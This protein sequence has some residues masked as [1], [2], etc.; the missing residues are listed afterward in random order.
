MFLEKQEYVSEL[1]EI[2][3]N[4]HDYRACSLEGLPKAGLHT[5]EVHGSSPCVSTNKKSEP[6]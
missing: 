1:K 6:I 5:Q 2:Y 4:K 3:L